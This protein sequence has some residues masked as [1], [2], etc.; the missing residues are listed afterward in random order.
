A[1]LFL[2]VG[3]TSTDISLINN[4]RGMVDYAEVGGHRTY[5]RSLDVRTVGVAGGSMIRVRDGRLV[6]VGPRSA[7]IA[8]LEYAAFADPEALDGAELEIFAPLPGDPE[9]YV[10]VRTAR[11][12]RYALTLTDAANLLGRVGPDDYARGN[13][14]GIRR[15]WAPLA[16]ALGTTVEEAAR[17]AL[18]LAAQKVIEPIEALRR[19]YAL[20]DSKVVLV[21]GGGAPCGGHHGRALP[22]RGERGDHLHHRGGPGH[23]PGDHRALHHQPHRGGPPPHPPGGPGGGD[24]PGGRPGHRR[25]ADRGDPRR[26]PG[27]GR[28]DRRHRAADGDGPPGPAECG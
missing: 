27:P 21:G 14:D 6:E 2:E 10:A 17:Q 15:A 24:R 22:D 3:G 12:E 11:G 26:A 19:K 4:G 8:G 5:L 18:D 9:E 1:G 20:E 16:A 23:D 28:G 25:G 7:H 13:L